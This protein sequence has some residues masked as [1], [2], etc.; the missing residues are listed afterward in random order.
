MYILIDTYIKRKFDM[1]AMRIVNNPIVNQSYSFFNFIP[2]T[3]KIKRYGTAE[4]SFKRKIVLY[5][6]LRLVKIKVTNLI[7]I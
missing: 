4:S 3:I 6:I 2:E 1:I 7:I 5:F